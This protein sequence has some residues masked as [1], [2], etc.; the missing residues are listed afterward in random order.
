MS[1][2]VA[3]ALAAQVLSL[4]MHPYLSPDQVDRVADAVL[5]AA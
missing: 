3:E 4:P 1:L 2:P 5:A